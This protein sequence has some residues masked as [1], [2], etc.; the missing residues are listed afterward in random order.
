MEDKITWPRD[1]CRYY[2]ADFPP[3]GPSGPRKYLYFPN[4]LGSAETT[5]RETALDLVNQV[6]E[7]IMSIEAQAA[8]IEAR[9]QTLARGACE[10]LEF[11]GSRIRDL[12]AARRTAEQ[13]MQEAN[14][15]AEEAEQAFKEAKFAR[16]PPKVNF[17]QWSDACKPRRHG[18]MKRRRL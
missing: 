2:V 8:D 1:P 10:K 4:A 13:G 3:N 16:Q 18:L 7:V 9:A 15:R 6:A 17:A 14:L 11:A 5:E 12:E